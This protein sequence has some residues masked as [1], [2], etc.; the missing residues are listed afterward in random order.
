MRWLLVLLALSTGCTGNGL[1]AMSSAEVTKLCA[2]YPLE[3][4]HNCP[5]EI[6]GQCSYTSSSGNCEALIQSLPDSC[7]A[8]EDD[9]LAC[10]QPVCS[11]DDSA[12]DAFKACGVDVWTYQPPTSSCA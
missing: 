11:A 9:Y 4:F 6:A 3:K 10:R 2:E 7:N 5:V 12:C 1:A 8:T